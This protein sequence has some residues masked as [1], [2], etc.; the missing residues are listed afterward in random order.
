MGHFTGQ[1]R[2]RLLTVLAP[3][4]VLAMLV[5]PMSESAARTEE[6]LSYDDGTAEN[7]TLYSTHGMVVRFQAPPWARSVVSA[8]VYIGDPGRA[9]RSA[10]FEVSI[11]GLDPGDPTQPG[12]AA[13][14]ASSGD[15]YPGYS[16]VGVAFDPTV[17]LDDDEVFLD[18]RFFGKV[19][20]LTFGA[21][22]VGWDTSAPGANSSLGYIEGAWSVLWGVN[23]ML[24]AVVSDQPTPV[25][26]T[27]WGRLKALFR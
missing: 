1:R 7:Y 9:S 4:V 20:W 11:H 26:F 3:A 15:A 16:W 25:E 13:G 2:F 27:T 18:N 21:P 17:S 14:T 12:S 8:Q 22:A 6:V 24:R 19:A 10:E 23:V 5:C